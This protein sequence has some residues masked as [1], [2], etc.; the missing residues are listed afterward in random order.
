LRYLS[1]ICNELTFV[2]KWGVSFFADMLGEGTQM[3]SDTDDLQ[4]TNLY[5]YCNMFRL[6]FKNRHQAN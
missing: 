3:V 5:L 1:I 6:T 2:F 4:F